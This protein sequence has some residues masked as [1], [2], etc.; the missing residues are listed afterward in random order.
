MRTAEAAMTPLDRPR[1][2]RAVAMSPDRFR[3]HVHLDEANEGRAMIIVSFL[4]NVLVA[5]A[6]TVAAVIT[7]SSSLR[8]EAVHSW[9]DTGNECLV[10]VAACK[11]RRPAD[12]QHTL[13]YGR[14]SYVWS[15]FAS[16]GTLLLGAGVGIWQGVHELG[17]AGGAS[18]YLVGYLVIGVSF[19]LEGVSFVQT[20]RQLRKGADELGRDLFEHALATSNS[21]LRAVFTEDFTALVALIVAALGMALHQLTGVAAYDGVGSIVIGL[22]MVV[23]AAMLI[24][25]NVRLLAGKPIEPAQ[26]ARMIAALRAEPEIERVAFLYSEVIG[27]ERLLIIASVTLAGDHTQPELATTLRD[28]ERRLMKHKYVGLAVLTL[29]THDD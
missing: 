22:L 19:A 25:R 6:K 29:A 21:T 5:T 2:P 20:I 4:A 3:L 12:D 26:R 23:A 24:S 15:L 17:E 27:P 13:G 14:E 11:A 9:V 28:L 18:D 1:T 7:R 16:I 8:T 10:V